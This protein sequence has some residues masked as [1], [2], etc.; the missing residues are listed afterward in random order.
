MSILLKAIYK[1]NAIP[2]KLQMVFFS[3]NQNIKF[4]NLY[5]NTKKPSIIKAILR[6][7]NGTGRIDLSDFRLYSKAT[8]IK[9]VWLLAQRQ[10]YRS[11]DQNGKPGDKSMHLWKP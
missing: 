1:F 3:Q 8:V 7:K 9:A 6:K 4:H 11:M 10:K 2:I 5:R